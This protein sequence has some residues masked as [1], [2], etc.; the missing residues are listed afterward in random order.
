MEP[1]VYHDQNHFEDFYGGV[2]IKEKFR[3]IIEFM[4]HPER[5]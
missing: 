4:H 5:F 1:Q 2:L 3:E